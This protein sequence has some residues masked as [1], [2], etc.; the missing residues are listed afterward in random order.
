MPCI[1]SVGACSS[2]GLERVP[3]KDEVAGSRPVRHPKAVVRR[4]LV[5]RRM[6]FVPHI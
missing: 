3:V 6:A 5:L 2:V 4:I 1:L